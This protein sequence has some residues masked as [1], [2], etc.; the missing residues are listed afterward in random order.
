MPEMLLS[1]AVCRHIAET[2]ASAIL[3]SAKD[4]AGRVLLDATGVMFAASGQSPDVA[5]FIALAREGGAGPCSVLGTD[6]TASAPMAALANGAMAHALDYE[7]AFDAAPGHPNA[8]LVPAAL[9]LAQAGALC[10]LHLREIAINS[11]AASA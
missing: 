5:P 7:D 3:E 10:P 1:E 6:V 8:S 2:P 9:A 11:R 4:A